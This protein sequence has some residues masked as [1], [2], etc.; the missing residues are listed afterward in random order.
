M[1]VHFNVWR[2]VQTDPTLLRYASAITEPMKCWELL[3]QKF[4][5]FQTLRNNF[6]QRATGCANG[7]NVEHPTM[8][9]VVG[10][11]CCATPRRSRNQ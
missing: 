6:Q 9:E 1:H 4:D 5:P 2:A 11:H 7:R 8:L 10:Q 3:V